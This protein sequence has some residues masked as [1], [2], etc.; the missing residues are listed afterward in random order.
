[1][2]LLRLNFLFVSLFN[3]SFIFS[4][5]AISKP[6]LVPMKKRDFTVGQLRVFNGVKSDANPEGRVLLAVV[7]PPP[8]SQQAA[9][10][11]PTHRTVFDVTLRGGA[12][13]GPGI[14]QLI[15]LHPSP[16]HNG[17]PAPVPHMAPNFIRIP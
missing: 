10:A 13:Y 14:S 1:M 3:S 8:Q 2:V 7:A 5:K 17:P 16:S 12:F 15:T 6:R 11:K 4:N 9:G